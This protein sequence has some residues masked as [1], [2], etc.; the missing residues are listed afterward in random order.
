MEIFIAPLNYD[1]LFHITKG[2]NVMELGL[3][4]LLSLIF[5]VVGMCLSC[6]VIGVIPCAISLILAIIALRNDLYARWPS[7][8]GIICSAVGFVMFAVVVSQTNGYEQA[9]VATPTDI[10]ENFTASDQTKYD[11]SNYSK[12]LVI[13][14]NDS[15]NNDNQ[16][17]SV[18]NSNITVRENESNPQII[19]MDF[20]TFHLKYVSHE[21][22]ADYDGNPCVIIYYDFTNNDDEPQSALL[23]VYS[24]V[25]QNGIECDLAYIHD[26]EYTSN[27]SKD[28]QKGTTI[29]VGSAYSISDMSD[30]DVIVKESFSFND[31]SDKMTLKLSQ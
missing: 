12:E 9:N 30:V 17:N 21:V 18:E 3:I 10:V 13:E 14:N 19:D 24:Q 22:S 1:I 23:A 20:D 29:R 7:I 15:E 26:N 27:E 6:I 11:E 4:S 16:S 5:G 28:V 25:F 2:D 31:K 8:C